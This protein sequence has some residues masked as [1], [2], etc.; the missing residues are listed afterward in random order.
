M[1]TQARMGR[2]NEREEEDGARVERR[3]S[4]N[5]I[6]VCWLLRFKCYL[7]VKKVNAN[8]SGSVCL[9]VMLVDFETSL[10]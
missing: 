4:I 2:E 6:V 5:R 1:F 7:L 9:P 8:T 3:S 10:H